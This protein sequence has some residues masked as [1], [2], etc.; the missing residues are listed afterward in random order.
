MKLVE[1]P[2]DAMQG[3]TEY[4]PAKVKA[5]Y[6]NTLLRVGFDTI[7]FGSFVSLAA[8]PQLRDTSEV[9]SMLDLKNTNTKL[10]AIIANL[11]GAEAAL[12]FN[13]ISYLGFP[14]SVSSKFLSLN[15]N[16]DRQKALQRIYD[17]NNLIESNAGNSKKSLLVYL[18][19]A[20]GNPYGELWSVEIIAKA[21]EELIHAGVKTI[22]LADTL[23]DGNS[24]T[25]SQIFKYAIAAYPEIEFGFHMHTGN[26]LKSEVRSRKSEVINSDSWYEKLDAAYKN[27]CRRFDSVMLGFGGC[28]MSNKELIGNLSTENLLEYFHSNNIETYVNKDNYRT[29]LE[30]AN[31]IFN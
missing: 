14:H 21:I 25:I 27:G 11:R 29:A 18:S 20:F 5:D 2:R 4:I 31:Q 16:S 12:K 26:E 6:I 30:Q 8:I 22:I 23:G 3:L 1:C 7:D 19:L 13:E 28:P 17:I 9:I 15:I 24:E 10:L